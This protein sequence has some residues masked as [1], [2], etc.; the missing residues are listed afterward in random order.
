[1][2]RL[3]QYLPL[4]LLGFV[5]FTAAC[6]QA[7]E[8]TVAIRPAYTYTVPAAQEDI[9]RSF[10]GKLSA[11][12]GVDLS[13]EVSGRVVKVNAVQGLR[14]EQ[15]AVLAQVDAADARVRLSDA[16]AALSQATQE[17][18]RVQHLFETGNA[19]QSQL[20]SAVSK[21][22]S[23]RANY[24]LAEIQVEN[25]KLLMPYAGVIASVS[26]DVEQFVSAGQT[27]I[28]VQGEGPMNFI[29]GVPSKVVTQVVPGAD[30]W[31]TIPDSTLGRVLGTVKEVAPNSEENTTYL[32]T[33]TLLEVD[34]SLREGMD[35]EAM[36][37]LP[38]MN[39]AYISVPLGSVLGGADDSQH[40]WV[41]VPQA[42]VNAAVIERRDVQVGELL[43][44]GSVAILKGLV[45]GEQVLRRGVHRVEAG[46]VVRIQK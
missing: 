46:M 42:G 23:N 12:Q 38:N 45:A 22:Q 15:G 16:K 8:T 4:P 20:D 26:V 13:F 43:A 6:D 1:M 24:E 36:I 5:L 21:E 44:D 30:V 31:V 39:G 41:V 34:A 3:N 27:V 32:V 14:F 18:R 10:S 33:A 17:L 28:R 37:S 11:S 2:K 7:T 25:C 40:V 29:F 9:E 35:G 19:S